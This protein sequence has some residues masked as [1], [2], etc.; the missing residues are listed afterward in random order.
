MALTTALVVG[1]VAAGAMQ[2]RAANRASDAQRDSAD[3]ATGL[4]RDMYYQTR[5]DQA[6]WR[7]V[8]MGALQMLAGVYNIPF[9]TN[10]DYDPTRPQSRPGQP[11]QP[12]QGGGNGFWGG[13]TGN[14]GLNGPA[15]GGM[16]GRMSGMQ[17]RPPPP[18]MN[19]LSGPVQ[20]PMQKGAPMPQGQ[21]PGRMG[22][23]GGMAQPQ[24][25][26]GPPRM[27]I[28]SRGQLDGSAPYPNQPRP[29]VPPGQ[30]MPQPA[31]GAAPGAPN[32]SA[33]FQS[34]DYQFRMD[35]GV[36][37]LDR[38]AAARGRTN[39]GAQMK[40]LTEYGSGLAS[41]EFG[42]WWNRL[43]NLAGLGP[44]ANNATQQAGQN[45]ANNAGQNMLAAGNARASQ[46]INQGNAW[47]NAI[48]GLGQWAGY[49]NWGG[50]SGMTSPT[51]P[52]QG[53]QGFYGDWRG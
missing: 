45:Y 1:T 29:A 21:P 3:A 30:P 10:P 19:A 11:A 27:G 17:D 4:Q 5:E 20:M 16:P 43:S 52:G 41:S 53:G 14:M 8:G 37:A 50:G 39:S 47:G 7:N 34:P 13:V 33:F 44:A 38:S 46:Y 24:T 49:Q 23:Q 15:N 2:S 48:N 28:P 32:Y 18:P 25:P 36:Q 9:S 40:A 51:S 42:N 35:Q 22:A 6:P 26:P 31:P 12:G